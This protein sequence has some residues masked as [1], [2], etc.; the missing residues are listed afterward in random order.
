MILCYFRETQVSN[1][2]GV[3]VEQEVSR[4][5]VTV[6]DVILAE[7]IKTLEDLLGRENCTRKYWRAYH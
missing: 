6:H 7:M 5:E 2:Y 1:L 4:L 3:I